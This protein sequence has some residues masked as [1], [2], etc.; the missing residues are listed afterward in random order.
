[1]HGWRRHLCKCK[2]MHETKCSFSHCTYPKYSDC[3]YSSPYNDFQIHLETS[4]T[5]NISFETRVSCMTD[6]FSLMDGSTAAGLTGVFSRSSTVVEDGSVQVRVCLLQGHTQ[7]QE[8][9]A[10]LVYEHLQEL[11][12]LL[13]A[14]RAVLVQLERLLLAEGSGFTQELYELVRI[15][16]GLQ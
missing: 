7:L 15:R 12:H 9:V 8:M 4:S 1:M 16:D 6:R 14:G 5:P 3:T 10:L 11:L 2:D 13:S